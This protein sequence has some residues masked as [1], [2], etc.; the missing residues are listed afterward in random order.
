MAE[1]T[2]FSLILEALREREA[3]QTDGDS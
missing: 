2:L 1:T 3:D